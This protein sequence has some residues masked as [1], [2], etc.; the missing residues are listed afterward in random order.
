MTYNKPP[1][2]QRNSGNGN[3]HGHSSAGNFPQKSNLP[4]TSKSK[5]DSNKSPVAIQANNGST[6]NDKP[7][8]PQDNNDII[9]LS[10]SNKDDHRQR[11]IKETT[12]EIIDYSPT[13]PKDDDII[14]LEA[15]DP[16]TPNKDT[17]EKNTVTNSEIEKISDKT[18]PDAS[19]K[20]DYHTENASESSQESIDSN[21]NATNTPI[22]QAEEADQTDGKQITEN[23]SSPKEHKKSKKKKKAKTS[24]A[25]SKEDL[26]NVLAK[27][28][29]KEI[30]KKGHAIRVDGRVHLYLKKTRT[31]A[32]LFEKEGDK[33]IRKYYGKKDFS[34][35]TKINIEILANLNASDDIPEVNPYDTECAKKYLNFRNGVLDLQTMMLV[36]KGI[37]KMH[38][39]RQIPVDYPF[40]Y[41]ADC[42]VFL[43]FLNTTF[44]GDTQKI[45]LVRKV[46]A[47]ILS[48]VRIN[49]KQAIILIGRS[50]SGK[51]VLGQT[52]YDLV[53]KESATALRPDQFEQNFLTMNL[54]DK[55]LN[56]AAEIS[57]EQMKTTIFR[58]STGGD[59]IL[60]DVKNS[61]SVVFKNR[62]IHVIGCKCL[63]NFNAAEDIESL[64]TR[65]VFITFTN[66]IPK[67][68]QDP[69]LQFKI[70]AEAP[71]I[72]QWALGS[73]P[74]LLKE[75]FILNSQQSFNEEKKE[76]LLRSQFPVDAFIKEH[77][78][79]QHDNLVTKAEIK[80]AFQ[81]YCNF[82]DIEHFDYRSWG[83]RIRHYI[84]QAQD[85]SKRLPY[86][87]TASS[88][89]IKGIAIDYRDLKEE[90]TLGETLR[91]L[92]GYFDPETGAIG[93]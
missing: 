83:N 76:E 5:E 67:K 58:Q 90:E 43:D 32:G 50:D 29:V 46:F 8:I 52:I 16:K 77:L 31:F 60:A 47:L 17:S 20:V 18:N 28:L 64:L 91:E 87:G 49:T 15:S 84:P 37:K 89:T 68:E 11:Y 85:N 51:S 71:G 70:N 3:P 21:T 57:P 78:I 69:E 26:S 22:K 48:D 56:Y 10:S 2:P 54:V 1:T 36:E 72:V 38:F 27:N 14:R 59:P 34:P 88:R 30:I 12:H 24:R 63:P 4:P 39:L 92:P 66:I 9:I 65:F 73:F 44:T 19:T 55:Y 93:S 82:Y 13:T 41:E 53:G 40:D 6:R 86:K 42:P 35:G 79:P 74:D 23:N 45:D 75:K 25:L 33:V 62:A 61:S 7:P 80:E 81:K